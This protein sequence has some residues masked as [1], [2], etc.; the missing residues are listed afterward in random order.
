LKIKGLIWLDEIIEKIEKKHNVH[1]N[2]VREVLVKQ[3]YFRF[4]EKGHRQGENVYSAMGQTNNG[5]YLITF[6]VHKK[7][8][9]ALIL[10]ARDMTK[11]EDMRKDRS[12]ISKAA[13][14]KEI[15]NFWDKHD[16]SDFWNKTEE[17]EFEVDIKSEITYYA[18]DKTLSEQIQSIARKRGVSADTLINLWVQEKLHEQNN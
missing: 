6:F 2:E 4:V 8:K 1:Q 13:S 16:L 12:P 3:P 10:T 17:V 7:D 14:Y 15:G 18:L 5:R 11:G 9:R